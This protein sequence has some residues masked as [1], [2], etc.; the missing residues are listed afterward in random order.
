MTISN[1]G[2]LPGVFTLSERNDSN[3]FQ[4]GSLNLKIQDIA[5]GGSVVYNG[6]R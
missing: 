4:S 5:P 2:S 1:T 6:R 3:G